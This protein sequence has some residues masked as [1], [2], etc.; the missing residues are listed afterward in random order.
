MLGFEC[1]EK[2]ASLFRFRTAGVAA[3]DHLP[4]TLSFTCRRQCPGDAAAHSS[5]LAQPFQ[6][7][8]V[9][10][11]GSADAPSF[12]RLARRSLALTLALSS[13]RDML[14]EGFCP[15]RYLHDCFDCFRLERFRVGLHLLESAALRG[16]RQQR[17]LYQAS[18]MANASASY[19]WFA[20]MADEAAA[21]V[22][23]GKIN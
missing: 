12:S 11:S 9:W 3:H 21:R 5:Q 15:L 2:G 7:F 23:R 22:K 4:P 6:P 14:I 17:T 10:Q 8:P 19:Q 1:D 16:A 13:I 18:I 20:D